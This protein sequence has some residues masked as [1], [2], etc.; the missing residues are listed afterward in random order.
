MLKFSAKLFLFLVPIAALLAWLPVNKRLK[1]QNLSTN[2]FNH[3]IWLYDRLHNNPRNASIVFLGSSRTVNSIDDKT[4]EAGLATKQSEVVNLGYCQLG[5]SLTHEL[6]KDVVAN[7]KPKAIIIEVREDEDRYSHPVFPYVAQTKDVLTSPLL[8]NPDYFSDG[9]KNIYYKLEIV[10]KQLFGEI[11]SQDTSLNNYGFA[12]SIGVADEKQLD[13]AKHKREQDTLEL[14]TLARK[15]Y[16]K[17]PRTYLEQINT[18]CLANNVRLLFLYIPG[19]GTNIAKPK[20]YD[21]YAK[22]GSVLIPPTE[23]FKNKQHW[24]DRDHLNALGASAFSSWLTIE[25]NK[26]SL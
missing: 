6:V 10:H 9:Y 17:Y 2:C 25:L 12:P 18:L 8:F 14:S 7:K 19:Y 24:F 3:G 15:F 13:E 5:M 11:I 21:T 1:Y 20:E 4:I 16:M 26:R 23:I 22:Y